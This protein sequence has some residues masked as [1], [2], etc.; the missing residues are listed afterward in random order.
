MVDALRTIHDLLQ[1]HGVLIEIHPA[2]H[3]PPIYVRVGGTTHLA[4]WVQ[5][6][7]DYEEYAQADAAI[8]TVIRRG[9]FVRERYESFTFITYADSLA[10]LRAHLA[11]EWSDA[12]IEEQVAGQIEAWMSS[13]T[14]DKEIILQEIVSI[15]RLQPF[16]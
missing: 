9:L 10:E 4:G 3:P 13:A 2:G 6:S 12:V 14:A 5:E 11:E 16:F 15:S 1:P 8:R 7:D